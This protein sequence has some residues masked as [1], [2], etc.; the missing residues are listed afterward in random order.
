MRREDI[1]N[2]IWTDTD[3]AELSVPSQLGYLWS[4]TNSHVGMSGL[5][6]LRVGQMGFELGL[7]ADDEAEVWRELA[8]TRFAY[9]EDGV[10]FVRS[11]VKHLRT[12]GEKMRIS[13]VNDLR[14]IRPDH[15]LVSAF[16]EEYLFTKWLDPDLA[17]FVSERAES[18]NQ[19]VSDGLAMG[20]QDGA[21]TNGAHRETVRS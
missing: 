5:Y 1:L 9:F 3:F 4:F 7:T 16:L 6:K 12:R 13:V 21:S 19:A 2:T 14:Q 15:P 20:S 17:E 10:V 8:E 11:R 18:L